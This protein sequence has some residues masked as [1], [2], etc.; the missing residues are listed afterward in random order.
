MQNAFKF[1]FLSVTFVKITENIHS[2]DV[3]HAD[4]IYLSVSASLPVASLCK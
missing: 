1:I 4:K 2:Y 3:D